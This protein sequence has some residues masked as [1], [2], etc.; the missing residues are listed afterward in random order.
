MGALISC[1][2][3]R[4]AGYEN[5]D[6]YL[7]PLNIFQPRNQTSL[8]ELLEKSAKARED[9]WESLGALEPSLLS[10]L[11]SSALMG[12]PK[13]PAVRQAFRLV[14]RQNGN[15]LIASD[16]LSDPFDDITLGTAARQRKGNQ[17]L[18]LSKQDQ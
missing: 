9:L 11:Q 15:V 14:K 16:G 18:Y 6:S 1:C 10:Q 13:W 7:Q 12:A 8:D 5:P 4:R 3:G 2:C 17:T